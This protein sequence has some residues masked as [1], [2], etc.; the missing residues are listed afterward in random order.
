MNKIV[1]YRKN[2]IFQK[3]GNIQKN[4]MCGIVF[5]MMESMLNFSW[6]IPM[7]ELFSLIE[8][9][10]N[11]SFNAFCSFKLKKYAQI[12]YSS[13]N[14]QELCEWKTEIAKFNAE[15]F[16]SYKILMY[17]DVFIVDISMISFIL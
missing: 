14:Q 11:K 12:K 4:V 1:A 3:N 10:V 5:V 15:M 6:K 13:I 17:V 8:N 9:V 7:K 2:K 16:A